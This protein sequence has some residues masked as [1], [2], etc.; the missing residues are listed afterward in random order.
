MKKT[1]K[2]VGIVLAAIIGLFIV[3]AV[4]LTLSFD[5]NK[6]KPEITKA[7]KDATGR[8]L[9]L[10]GDIALSFFPWI[11]A[12]IGEVS[13]ANA[14]GFGKEPFA[15][16]KEA[17]VKVK[18]L[19]LLRGAVIVDR[20][21]L[22]GLKLNLAKNAAGK[23]NWDDLGGKPAAPAAATKP[24]APGAGVGAFAIGG[25]VVRDGELVWDDRQ[26]G[27]RYV[28]HKLEMKSGAIG[29]GKPTDLHIGFELESGK[30]A[31]RTPVSLDATLAVD[32]GKQTLSVPKLTLAALGM[33][34]KVTDLSGTQIVD[35]P[36]FVGKLDVAPFDAKAALAKL[37]TK[38]ETTDSSA[39]TQVGVATAFKASAQN[40]ELK[41]L[42]IG[43]DGTRIAGSFAIQNLDKPAY[44]FD[45]AAG[46]L[47]LDRYMP[48]APAEQKAA[49]GDAA[50]PAPQPV[51][52]PF[53]LM[54]DLNVDGK[55]R[56]EK[57]KATGIRST[58]V[59]TRLR[60]QGGVI[61]IK[62]STAKLYGGSYQGAIGVDARG[63]DLVLSMDENL[64]G[65]SIGPMLKDMQAFE[66]FS[67]TGDVSIKVTAR[68]LDG[69]QFTRSLTGDAAF[70]LRDGAIQGA[71]ILKKI[72]ES[73]ALYDQV[74]GK[75][76]RVRGEKS[77]KTAFEVLSGTAKIVNGIAE[78]ND[79]LLRTPRM[80]ATG[81]GTANLVEETL[82]FRLE[83]I[84]KKNEGKKC[85]SIPLLVAGPFASLSY[86]P[87][88]EALLKCEAEKRVGEKLD[89][90]K[91]EAKEKLREKGID[92][93]L[94]RRR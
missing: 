91:E 39:L 90:T 85:A 37:G 66:N 86:L 60:A 72:E 53:T 88:F 2:I 48:P 50:Q 16:V 79:L 45:L 93:D 18:L 73:R 17:G 9:T 77:E 43:L 58:D 59:A 70:S 64:K 81:R 63:K 15:R 33:S 49:T 19:P 54:R 65:I 21:Y 87:D 7:V 36:N 51:V 6:Y 3:A 71:D 74:K 80:Q 31:L 32:L 52:I 44:R 20:I 57:L 29:S 41:D 89:K 40:V 26:A 24:D 78:N 82:N 34:A 62:P 83:V 5:P 47:D 14:A 92:L 67:G 28:V 11:G 25:I 42:A 94:F 4:I 1:A 61:D 10:A 27:S 69:R 55:L 75:P 46:D 8:E 76:P 84:E 12:E 38:I 68:G 30:P 56:I 13:L 23:S 35:A 22:D